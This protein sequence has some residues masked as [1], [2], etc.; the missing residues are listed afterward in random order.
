MEREIGVRRVGGDGEALMAGE[1]CQACEF[2]FGKAR[3]NI[4]TPHGVC[5]V[6]VQSP[7]G[8]ADRKIG[9]RLEPKA[10]H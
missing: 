7:H 4:Q 10:A 1:R 2:R 9:Q 8:G 3:R 5:Q 6:A